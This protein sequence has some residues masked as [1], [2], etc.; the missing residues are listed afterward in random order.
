MVETILLVVAGY[1]ALWIY[2]FLLVIRFQNSL[3]R[4]YPDRANQI[5]GTKKVFG[6]NAKAGLLFLW[7]EDIKE[8]SRQNKNTDALR[9]A[10]A[11]FIFLLLIALFLLVPF[12]FMIWLLFFKV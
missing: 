8:L 1:F 11:R 4:S 5:L 3:Y 6:I 9:R 7:R 10:A 2:T 12:I